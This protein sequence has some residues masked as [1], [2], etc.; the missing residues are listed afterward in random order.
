MVV[1]F[2][3]YKK[4]F[5][6][7]IF[8]F[9]LA[10][11]AGTAN[12]QNFEAFVD[13]GDVAVG[14]NI[15]VKLELTGTNPK[16]VPDL[17]TLPSGLKITGQS[18]Q[19]SLEIVNGRQTSSISW[20]YNILPTREGSYNIPEIQIAT[21]VGTLLTRPFKINVKDAGTLPQ[22]TDD[23][24]VFLESTLSKEN[25]YVG[26]PTIYTTRIYSKYQLNDADL[27]K[28]VSE[29]LVFDQIGE[30]KVGKQI[31][32]GEYYNLVTV[33][34][35][36]TPT[37]V[38]ANSIGASVLKGRIAVPNT[39]KNN[40]IGDPFF[41]DVAQLA[42][43][44]FTIASKAL[45]LNVKEPNKNIQDWLPAQKLDAK[46]EITGAFEGQ[47][48]TAK[49]GEPFTRKIYLYSEGRFGKSLPDIEKL[50][51]NENFK[52]YADKPVESGEIKEIS[53]DNFNLV[54]KKEQTFNYVPQTA[55]EFELPEVKINWWNT[56]TD[57]LEY[58]IIPAKKITV[59]NTASTNTTTESA[60]TEQ[61]NIQKNTQENAQPTSEVQ[62]PVEAGNS[63]ATN[64]TTTAE[65]G[66]K[67]NA[68]INAAAQANPE[69]KIDFEQ[70][71]LIMIGLGI[72]GLLALKLF[73]TKPKNEATKA[74][75]YGQNN[76]VRRAVVSELKTSKTLNTQRFYS[77]S[78]DNILNLK[79]AN[80]I[81]EFIQNFAAQNLSMAKNNSVIAIAEKLVEQQ[82]ANTNLIDA[83]KALDSAIFAGKDVDLDGI[84]QAFSLAIKSPKKATET[85]AK[86]NEKLDEL[87]PF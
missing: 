38:G 19:S 47:Q 25:V 2:N 1:L 57:A 10:S 27:K 84:K 67:D 82:Q 59:V 55:G 6:A 68:S 12:A 80:E 45:N 49:I 48:F 71:L 29:G 33:N 7:A 54:G 78:S 15:N 30:P 43:T 32:N 34:F 26:E 9:I 76:L 36:V 39:Q 20:I 53:T 64:V 56:Q 23:N 22:K 17:S 58:A 70:T 3:S 46:D 13:S 31:L 4:V 81:A 5:L 18:Q 14:Q 79:D 37:K 77:Q 69:V 52:I 85:P 60:P 72:F 74:N 40:N 83:A 75:Y 61:A 41:D 73:A 44:P 65:T 16:G 87:N 24:S 42:V 86:P 51:Q 11:F 50:V 66:A 62:K 28:P 63:I 21:E 8:A 35:L